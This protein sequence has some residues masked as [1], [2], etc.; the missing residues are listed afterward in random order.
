[1]KRILFALLLTFS[2]PAFAE[3]SLFGKPP[4]LAAIEKGDLQALRTALM[5]DAN[6]NVSWMGGQTALMLAT[7]AGRG[8]MAKLLLEHR[9]DANATDNAGLTAMHYAAEGTEPELID[10]LVKAGAKVN[11]TNREGITPLMVAAREGRAENVER[12]LAKDADK[13]RLD[14]TGRSAEDWAKDG[15][16]SNVIRLL[17]G[18]H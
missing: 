14:F 1:M 18:S 8:D 12:L 5:A 2:L 13:D 3:V 16:N 6:A 9:A 10:I 17:A 7:I 15:R 4:V 11:V